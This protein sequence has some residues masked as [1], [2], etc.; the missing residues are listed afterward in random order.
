MSPFVFSGMA[1]FFFLACLGYGLEHDRPM[2]VLPS[3][4]AVAMGLL[5][6]AL[7]LTAKRQEKAQPPGDE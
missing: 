4:L 7:A 5:G 6:M 3:L 1:T 2:I